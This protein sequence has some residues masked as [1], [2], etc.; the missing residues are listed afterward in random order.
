MADCTSFYVYAYLRKNGSPYYIGK[1][2]DLRAWTKGKGEVKPP[3]DKTRIVIL[4]TNLSEVGAF[5]IER[6]MICWYGRKDINTG[7]LRNK[8]EGGDGVA[9]RIISLDQIKRQVATRIANGNTGKGKKRDPKLV[10]ASAAKL[11]GRKQT[12]EN[13]EKNAASKRGIKHLFPRNIKSKFQKGNKPWNLGKKIGPRSVASIMK[14]KEN[15]KGINSGPQRIIMCP[16]C[17]KKGGMSNMKRYHFSE[18]GLLKIE[19]VK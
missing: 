8:T 17:N 14:Q 19:G 4:E 6:R 11:R 5:A 2:K 15:A 16:H 1:G 3:K 18:C 12:A 10:E 13:R 7:I 9:G